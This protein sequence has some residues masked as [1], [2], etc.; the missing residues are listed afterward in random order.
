M[1]DEVRGVLERI[2]HCAMPEGGAGCRG[3]WVRQEGEMRFASGSRWLPFK[4]EKWFG[5]PGIDFRWQAWIRMAPLMWT[6]VVDSFLLGKGTLTAHVFGI[7][8][9]VRSRG[10]ATD[11][12]EALRG[13][14]ELPWRPFAFWET[15]HFTWSMAGEN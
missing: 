4:A 1:D 10:L 3:T 13:L 9:A 12:G 6:R 15:P 5:G 14:A 8:P 7:L 11:R 2:R